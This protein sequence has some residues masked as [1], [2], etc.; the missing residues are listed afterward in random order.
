MADAVTARDFAPDGTLSTWTYDLTA[1]KPTPTPT[2][3]VV[4]PVFGAVVMVPAKPVAGKKLVFTLAVKR[5]DTGAPLTTGTVICNP[6]VA[7]KLLKHS[8]SFAAGKAKLAVVVPKTARGKLLTVKVK[9]VNGTQ[10]ATK[11]V[12]YKVS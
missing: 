9:I 11:V 3:T 2:P 1:P 8:E 6:S 10:S 4:K 5:S 12:T 7:G